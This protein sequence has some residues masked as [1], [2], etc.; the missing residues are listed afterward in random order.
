M[1]AIK[2]Y[3]NH[4]IANRILTEGLKNVSKVFP[5]STVNLDYDHHPSGRSI[6]IKQPQGQILLHPRPAE[7]QVDTFIYLFSKDLSPHIQ[8]RIDKIAKQASVLVETVMRAQSRELNPD[9]KAEMVNYSNEHSKSLIIEMINHEK[10]SD[11]DLLYNEDFLFYDYDKTI[12]R[13][14]QDLKETL[15]VSTISFDET[16]EVLLREVNTKGHEI[17]K[18]ANP[19]FISTSTGE[20]GTDPETT[21]HDIKKVEEVV[22]TILSSRK[23]V[24]IPAEE[25]NQAQ[26]KFSQAINTA[27]DFN[28]PEEKVQNGGL[29]YDYDKRMNEAIAGNQDITKESPLANGRKNDGMKY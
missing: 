18:R 24:T 7:N 12:A 25:I 16:L 2:E 19:T 20:L 29:A 6:I 21:L 9:E 27:L 14:A 15:E 8:A 22:F 4:L 28:Q 23:N 17:A 26:L 11:Y 1:I 3:A 10:P 13:L 5:E